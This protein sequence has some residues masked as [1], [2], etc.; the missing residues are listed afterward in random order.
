MKYCF[1][2]IIVIALGGSII[3]P[4]QINYTFL[5]KFKKFILPFIARGSK[6]IVVAGGGKLSRVYQEAASKISKVTNEDKDWLGIHATRSN[7]H[8]L[9][10]I[11]RKVA[12]PVVIDERWKIRK[13]RYPITIASGWRPGWSTDF[14]AVQLADDFG[15]REVVIAGKPAYVYDRDPHGKSGRRARPLR[16]LSWRDYRKMIPSRWIP[17]SHAPVDPVAAKLAQAKRIKAIIID[18]RNL[19]N[20]SKLLR[21]ENFDGTIISNA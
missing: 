19:K 14:I 12:D 11:F 20:F 18:G 10:T 16:E 3:Y 17:G 1:G 13:L 2:K 15:V 6:F 5:R 7:A 21:G 9:R 8:L 4:E